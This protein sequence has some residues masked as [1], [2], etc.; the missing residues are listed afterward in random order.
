[1]SRRTTS[2]VPA[3]TGAAEAFAGG[4]A[5]LASGDAAQAAVR[6][7]V[8]L[9]LEPGYAG[10]VLAAIGERAVDPA[11]TLVAGDALRLLGRESE[12][13]AAFHLA[14]G[15]VHSPAEPHVRD[16]GGPREDAPG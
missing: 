2:A 8:A 3:P 10:D 11:L 6:L 15:H 1:V 14:R 5:A 13:L 16:A 12:A 9:R 4:R 7:G